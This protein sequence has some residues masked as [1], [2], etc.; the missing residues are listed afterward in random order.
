MVVAGER[1]EDR[2]VAHYRWAE[3][4]A[5]AGKVR[6]AL[7]H[8]GRALDFGAG[9]D[10]FADDEASSHLVQAAFDRVKEEFDAAR[11]RR[12]RVGGILTGLWYRKSN[13]KSFVVMSVQS[14]GGSE[15]TEEA[16][17]IEVQNPVGSEHWLLAIG[18]AL[19]ECATKLRLSHE[20]R[21]FLQGE[22]M[23]KVFVSYIGYLRRLAARYESSEQERYASKRRRD[24]DYQARL[25]DAYQGKMR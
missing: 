4:Y 25:H 16:E 8:F 23:Q 22:I 7:A 12:G 5:K 2:G 13:G 20:S 11:D 10:V 17:I 21:V 24:D 6:K 3:R 15:K 18:K 14:D 9:S 19:D 1:G